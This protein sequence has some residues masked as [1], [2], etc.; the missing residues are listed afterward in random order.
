MNL[1]T[2]L[3]DETHESTTQRKLREMVAHKLIK[4]EK[5]N[6]DKNEQSYLIISKKDL[7]HQLTAYDVIYVANYLNVGLILQGDELRIYFNE[8]PEQFVDDYRVDK[9]FKFQNQLKSYRLCDKVAYTIQW[10]INIAGICL[11]GFVFYTIWNDSLSQMALNIVFCVG[12]L[13]F[14]SIVNLSFAKL[15]QK[16]ILNNLRKVLKQNKI[17]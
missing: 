1:E 4:Y 11:L 16:R 2:K 3:F 17:N 7:P 9:I 12:L 15:T 5:L 13:L 10:A 6:Q 14:F 8:E